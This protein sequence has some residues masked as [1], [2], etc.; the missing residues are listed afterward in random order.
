MLV[1]V[2]GE[3]SMKKLLV[4][5]LF[6]SFFLVGCQSV[7]TKENNGYIRMS[8]MTDSSSRHEVEV[9][10]KKNLKPENVDEFLEGVTD[11]NET[12]KQTSLN[13]GFTKT[14]H[15]KYDLPKI[16]KLWTAEK[17]DF[18]GTNCRINTFMLLKG[19]L[20]ISKG[21]IDDSLLFLDEEA[22]ARGKIFHEQDTETF[23]QLFSRVKTNGTK[24]IA[25]HASKMRAH[26]SK[27]RFDDQVKMIS[28]VLHDNLDGDY[29]FIGHVGVLTKIKDKYLFVEKLSFESP[30]Q[31]IIF[32]SK[33]ECYRY[34]STTY[35]DYQDETTAVPF[36]M[37][38]DRWVG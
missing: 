17:G 9:S 37:E 12:I 2:L 4:G 33:E 28:V 38:N 30:F 8:N 1:I 25:V 34:L 5:A 27:V 16:S 35:K 15:P 10:L 11:Y 31:A 20:S 29:L 19:N 22:I 13:K 3:N 24:N 32:N 23:K 6:L 36:I 14:K 18:I 7:S 26:F 21:K